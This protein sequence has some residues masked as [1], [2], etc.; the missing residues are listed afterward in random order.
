MSNSTMAYV[1]FKKIKYFRSPP[2]KKEQVCSYSV[3][4]LFQM[5]GR[6]KVVHHTGLLRWLKS[7]T[8][9]DIYTNTK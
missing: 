9:T 2:I 8:Y 7:F 6:K 3:A 4:S 5:I 1:I